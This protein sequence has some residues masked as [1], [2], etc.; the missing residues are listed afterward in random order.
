MKTI[1]NVTPEFIQN[2]V[3]DD[4]TLREWQDG[5]D[6]FENI[7]K[8]ERIFAY[9]NGETDIITNFDIVDILYKLEE[10]MNKIVAKIRSLIDAKWNKCLNEM[11]KVR[12]AT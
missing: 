4:N 11:N 3:D 7:W 1:T 5:L 9:S 8:H 12:G 10:N 6:S 2:I